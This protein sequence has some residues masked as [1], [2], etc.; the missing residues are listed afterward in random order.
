M[1]RKAQPSPL[2]NCDE[3]YKGWNSLPENSWFA[4]KWP[5]SFI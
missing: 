2:A 4:E 3:K 1:K 5:D